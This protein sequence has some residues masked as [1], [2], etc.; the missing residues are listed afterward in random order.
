MLTR[1]HFAGIKQGMRIAKQAAVN[2]ATDAAAE[3][4]KKL[5]VHSSSAGAPSEPQEVD[6]RAQLRHKCVDVFRERVDF[7]VENSMPD[8]RAVSRGM[9]TV[10][11]CN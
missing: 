4:Q 2:K 3:A 1:E 7:T 5:G 9:Q 8:G 10:L 11:S 6:E